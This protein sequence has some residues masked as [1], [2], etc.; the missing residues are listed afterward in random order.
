MKRNI[1]RIKKIGLDYLVRKLV[2][3]ERRMERLLKE[4]YATQSSIEYFQKEKNLKP[5][6]IQNALLTHRQE[7]GV[8]GGTPTGE[9]TGGL[10]LSVQSGDAKALAETGTP[11]I[12]DNTPV[13]EISGESSNR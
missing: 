8:V 2:K 5:E 6:E 4:Y 11:T 7:K 3:L 13:T 9:G 12:Q 1:G 10:Q